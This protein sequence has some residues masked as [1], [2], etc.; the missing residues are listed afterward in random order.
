MRRWLAGSELADLTAR[1]R[2]AAQSLVVCR[3]EERELH[4]ALE[5]LDAE[6]TSTTA[7]LSSRREEDL[8]NA[9]GRV[10]GL[11]ERARGTSAL[12]RE[13]GRA[14]V[15]ALDAAADVDVVSTLEAEGARLASELAAAEVDQEAGGAPERVELDAAQ[16]ALDEEVAALR[17]RWSAVLG[18]DVP[19][20]AIARVRGRAELVAR[21][22][23]REQQD[24]DALGARVVALEQR[25]AGAA[26]RAD[27]LDKAADDL[28]RS[29]AALEA[30]LAARAGELEAAARAAET[31]QA[32][33][34]EAEEGRYRTA[35]RAEALERALADLQGAG[36]VAAA[37]RR[38]GRGLAGRPGR[39]RRRVG[40]RVRGRGGRRGRRRGG[41]RP[42]IRPGRPGDAARAGRDGRR[43]GPAPC[44][45]ERH[46]GGDGRLAA[47]G[48]Q[49]R[50]RTRPMSGRA[51]VGPWPSRSSTPSSA[52]PSA[53][54]A[55]RRR[56]T[57]RS[58]AT[59]W[60][61]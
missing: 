32:A 43:A 31:S 29:T 5:R 20:E 59:T 44:R 52:V 40:R 56:S 51:R 7:E 27:L 33:A 17:E 28:E 46:R 16:A 6:A 25:A 36:G 48:Q 1:R 11:V 2:A 15:A 39:D 50:A 12:L 23:A 55:G 54:T 53:S 21:G 18:D 34:D 35:A 49:R 60:W 19:D 4:D 30:D 61:S 22:A 24:M 57:S 45:R 13:R 8:A 58:P 42:A 38:R 47:P 14:V 10:Q 41:R 3:D 37:P 26:V 9:L